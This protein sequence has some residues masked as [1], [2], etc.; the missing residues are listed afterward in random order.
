MPLF[1]GN[2]KLSGDPINNVS[3]ETLFGTGSPADGHTI[4]S[5][6]TY[7]GVVA[8]NNLGQDELLMSFPHVYLPSG[9]S[10]GWTIAVTIDG[11]TH[12]GTSNQSGGLGG[13]FAGSNN[14]GVIIGGTAADGTLSATE[15]SNLRELGVADSS[16][17]IGNN[18]TNLRWFTADQIESMTV[19]TTGAGATT[20]EYFLNKVVIKGDLEIDGAGSL[21]LSGVAVDAV[22]VI[23]ATQDGFD[24]SNISSDGTN[25]TITGDLSVDIK[26]G[27]ANI[28]T[29][30]VDSTDKRVGVG[31]VNPHTAIHSHVDSTT[32]DNYIQFTNDTTTSASTR[33]AYIGL[34]ADENFVINNQETGKGVRLNN[35]SG[36]GTRGIGVT[37]D[38]DI[39]EHNDLDLSSL[40]TGSIPGVNAAKTSLVDSGMTYAQNLITIPH[41][42]TVGVGVQG[43]T[44]PI[45]LGNFTIPA[46]TGLF[47]TLEDEIIFT[48]APGGARYNP[49]DLGA[50]DASVANPF[51][52]A[53]GLQ[54]GL[55]PSSTNL[56]T[57]GTRLGIPTT[58]G[59][60]TPNGGRVALT[61][62]ANGATL[63]WRPSSVT[64]TS[65]GVVRFLGTDPNT[66]IEIGQYEYGRG[67]FSNTDAFTLE[68]LA[69]APLNVLGDLEVHGSFI[70]DGETLDTNPAE[71][72]GT[73]Q[74]QQGTDRLS[75]WTGVKADYDT[76]VTNGD[77]DPNRLYNI[78]D[79]SAAEPGDRINFANLA[80]N[81]IPAVNT[82]GDAFTDSSITQAISAGLETTTTIG[83]H[84]LIIST[85]NLVNSTN[86]ITPPQAVDTTGSD[87]ARFLLQNA[88]ATPTN[89]IHR[90][91]AIDNWIPVSGTVPQEWDR[92]AD[93]TSISNNTLPIANADSTLFVDS[94][95]TQVATGEGGSET[96]V[97]IQGAGEGSSAS[98]NVNG[99]T[100]NSSGAVTGTSLSTNT[101][102]ADIT[103]LAGGSAPSALIY[104][105]GIVQ[106]IDLGANGQ[107][108]AVDTSLN[109]TSLRW[110]D[111]PTAGT[112]PSS[113]DDKQN[114]LSSVSEGEVF[115]TPTT[116]FNTDASWYWGLHLGSQTTHLDGEVGLVVTSGFQE[117]SEGDPFPSP[118]GTT[119]Q[120]WSGTPTGGTDYFVDGG[121][122]PTGPETTGD[123]YAFYVDANNWIMLEI[124]AQQ[125]HN[126]ITRRLATV[127]ASRGNIPAY[128]T[129]VQVGRVTST[130][131]QSL[132]N[133]LAVDTDLNV[134]GTISGLLNNVNPDGANFQI[135]A[136]TQDQFDAQ[137]EITDG[138][139]I[140]IIRPTP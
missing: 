16:V 92:I 100:I 86:E 97:T 37:A 57:L 114:T 62:A 22:P 54:I 133:S 34:D 126:Q 139:V 15:A 74:V 17:T 30:H 68:F 51:L 108:L 45:G 106:P 32:G 113:W 65:I 72:G 85:A 23:N 47:P 3:S 102:S 27:D 5:D 91:T 39:V 76:I 105:A 117:F 116:N 36:T 56:A 48:N 73:D 127:V 20:T 50:L 104:R 95:I 8:E 119:I 33:G 2:T 58:A 1:L 136:G 71:L 130:W 131:G 66:S 93:A 11:Y 24:A 112:V 81:T 46:G 140:Y 120:F 89:A 26:S 67:T 9:I 137:T 98:L 132:G 110:T 43:G 78:T 111:L 7:Y 88:S 138:S 129:A 21:D 29:L 53:D 83:G 38:G 40:S 63:V 52:T 4:G 135:W 101:A 96:V 115:D 55:Y 118:G 79:D 61:Q 19:T 122:F 35:L 44:T 103:N 128:Q 125:F 10:S 12:T 14:I 41:D 25:A 64:I 77:L 134:T 18:L 31:L 84:D 107:V 59:T 94:A 121:T 28:A 99:G 42:L 60:H 69:A 87:T 124:G 70:V 82:A 123:F 75:M 109:P 49:S 6:T 13:V 90:S 80:N